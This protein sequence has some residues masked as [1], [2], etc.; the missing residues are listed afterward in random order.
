M[1]KGV[2]PLE[3]RFV[4]M[5]DS[6]LFCALCPFSIPVPKYGQVISLCLWPTYLHRILLLNAKA[7]E[8][9]LTSTE[10]LIKSLK[11][12]SNSEFWTEYSSIQVVLA[13][14]FEIW[15]NGL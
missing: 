6:V 7:S 15:Y 12:Q 4:I 2:V 5:G 14:W 1:D 9:T 3:G 8:N 13:C 10:E 11:P